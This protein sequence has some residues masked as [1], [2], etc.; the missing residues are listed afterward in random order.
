M[1]TKARQQYFADESSLQ[2]DSR[3]FSIA[4]DVM[5]KIN[6]IE[7]WAQ[8]NVIETVKVNWTA[9]VPDAN[10][11]V[12]ID[13][14]EVI[15]N[16]YTVDS[17]N[18]LSAKQWKLLYDYIQNIASRW[19][20]LS[21]WNS[22]TW[23]P[24]TN[25]GESPYPYK[26]WDYFIVSNVAWLWGTNYRPDGSSY[27]I[28]QA[29]TVVETDGVD[30]SDFYFY[31]GTNWL[32]LKNSGRS[33]A[34]D[35]SLST[36]S[37]NPVENRVITNA[38]NWKQETLIAWNNIQIAADWKTISATNTT[39][40]T[41][42]SSTSWLVKL[43]SDTVQ[44]VAANAVSSTADRTYAVQLNSNDQMVVNVP[45][46]DTTTWSATSSV[47]GTLKLSSD[48]VQSEAAQTV[49][50]TSNRTYW[51]QVNSSW[52][53]V[54][55]V[56]WTDTT[57][58]AG[59]WI[60]IDSD[61]VISNTQT[62]AEWWNI[63]WTLSSQTDLQSALN[64]KQDTLTGWTWINISAQDVISADTTVLATKTD[65]SSKANAADLNV[66]AF[67][68]ASSS[69][70]ATAQAAYD[71]FNAWKIPVLCDNFD[72]VFLLNT[73]S[74]EEYSGDTYLVLYFYSTVDDWWYY[75]WIEV[76]TLNDTVSRLV[77][78]N[79]WAVLTS[80]NQTVAW[81]KTFSTSPVVPSKTS[82]ATN[83]G[84]AIATE[85]QVYKKQDTLVS[86]TN[87]KTINNTTLLWSG[88]I[89]TWDMS[90]SDFNWTAK[91]W[92]TITLSLA[93][94]ITPSANFT[95]NAPSTIKDWQTYI[96]RV[97]NGATA[98]TMTLWTNISNPFWTD[99]TLTANW[100]DQFVFLA[101]GWQLELQPEWW[102]WW[103]WW[104]ENDTT[105]T[106]T[107]VTKI[108]AGTEAEYALI[109]PDA[110]TIYYVF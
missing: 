104:I 64:D 93:S 19:R 72:N 109:T 13:V 80:W 23:L 21:N 91:T 63:T 84:T 67:K 7:T 78:V 43:W 37:T 20:F 92:A 57:Y 103:G 52:Q 10:K 71:W 54:V 31:D 26:S 65:L 35:S 98:Y 74:Y 69:D 108:W 87:I 30:V 24:M 28:W 48:T 89:T 41:A 110:T 101:I 32:L 27:V 61:N 53:G 14:P 94:T 4:D 40:S 44:S 75:N 6:S 46:S 55:N 25:P 66:K 73:Y 76:W 99:L 36:T 34:V 85:A 3:E 15:D 107:T 5:Q 22:A 50:S 97:D 105:G 102:G 59:T 42:T 33:W 83:T 90:Y 82:D 81:T 18:A 8:V 77:T 62:S 70:T 17:D 95:V 45:W 2:K 1:A 47:A 106:T 86:G 56:P 58:T 12:D 79:R 49:S 11:A 60:N 38:L 16:L 9:L 88:D 29:S 100:V 68:L 39:Y 96:L 51:L